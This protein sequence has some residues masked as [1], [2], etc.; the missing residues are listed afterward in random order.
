MCITKSLSTASHENSRS[1]IL[2]LICQF[3][4]YVC[5]FLIHLHDSLLVGKILSLNLD[6]SRFVKIMNDETQRLDPNISDDDLNNIQV[7]QQRIKV[8][9]IYLILSGIAIFT[10]ISVSLTFYFAYDNP[11]TSVFAL[12]SGML[13]KH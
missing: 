6:S 4:E 3:L 9:K 13:V 10:G 7:V 12:F 5:V 11:T 8:A 2:P 1:R